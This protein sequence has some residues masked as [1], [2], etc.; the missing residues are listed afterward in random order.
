MFAGFYG[1]SVSVSSLKA[2]DVGGDNKM[3]FW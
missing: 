2:G 1:C 3:P